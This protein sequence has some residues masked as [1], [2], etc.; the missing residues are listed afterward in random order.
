MT[1]AITGHLPSVFEA[2]LPALS[3]HEL[4]DPLEAHARIAAARRRSP[5]GL[6]PYGPEF[7]R[8]ADVHTVL[9]DPRFITPPSLG[10][11]SQGVTSGP[12]WNRATASILGIDGEAHSRLR[13]LVAKAFCPRAIARLQTLVESTANELVD[14]L[15]AA[16][17]GDIVADVSRRY[18]I[19]IICALLGAPAEDW[20]LF[21]DWADAI[22]KVFD[23]NVANDGPEIEAAWDELDAY[24]EAM[25]TQRRA[26]LTDDLISELIRAED[27]GDRLSHS[28]LL[29]LAGTTLAA[30]TDTT[31]NQL[32]AAIECLVDHP[33]QWD[34][35]AAN[36]DL[37][38][39]AVEELV[40]H[41]P[42]VLA[43][44]RCAIEDVELAG[45]TIP[46]GTLV[47]A[48]TA[49]ANRDPAVFDAPEELDFTREHPTPILTFGGGTHYCLGAHL[50]RLELS[51]GIRAITSRCPGISRTGPSPWK[52]LTGVTG[53]LT[54]PV[55]VAG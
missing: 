39:N 9:R 6:G 34:L 28:D 18:P 37:I 43:T 11:D 26:S 7:L 38:G 30:G 45:V 5:V 10:L 48:N 20:H 32:A 52:K 41:S 19:P 4:S 55:S 22:M 50:A 54:L 46:A 17:S 33:D 8:Y 35:L 3:Y 44:M 27:D 21:S 49:A 31:R 15:I 25:L 16:G 24:L 51:E 14:S 42:V 1:T 29:M 53:P 12:L 2:D 47:I 13:R 40:R 23:W 36:P